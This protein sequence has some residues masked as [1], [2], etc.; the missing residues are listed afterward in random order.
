MYS[1]LA[2]V[3]GFILDLCFGDPYWMWFHPVRLIG[4]LIAFLEK[5]LRKIFPKNSVGEFA[6]GTVLAIFVVAASV[7]VPY[8]VLKVLYGVSI[9]IGIA[10]ESIFC[11]F[12][13]AAKSLKSESM[14][15]YGALN[16]N[17]IK[18]AREAV[19]M[20]VG[21]DTDCLDKDGITKAAVETVAENL[22]DGV[23]A[24]MLYMVIFGA[25]GGFFYKAVN[26]MDSMIGYKNDKYIYFGRFA[27]ILDDF[28]NFIPSRLSAFIMIIVSFLDSRFDGKNAL[29]IFIRDRKKSSSPNSA[30]TESACA[31]ALGIRL[32][33]DAYYFGKLYKKSTIG[34]NINSIEPKHIRLANRLLY[35]TAF[36]SL[37]VMICVKVAIIFLW[38]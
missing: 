19:S 17:D 7:S 34:D 25:C 27:A 29:K 13:F 35:Q 8:A 32:L 37:I 38:R 12:L 23:T 24:P 31:G 1:L 20:I 10:A 16:E 30:Q 14:K 21:R 3:I 6:A 2:C 18:K 22:S 9:Y 36:L 26:T 4:S 5:I 28:V 33:G 15:V 11:Y